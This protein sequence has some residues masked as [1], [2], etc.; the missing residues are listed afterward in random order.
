MTDLEQYQKAR[1]EAL[2][3]KLSEITK[4]VK[5]IVM[6]YDEWKQQEPEQLGDIEQQAEVHTLTDAFQ[7]GTEDQQNEVQ[8][9][10][11][12]KLEKIHYVLKSTG[13]GLVSE[14]ELLIEKCK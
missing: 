5:E 12:E 1:I 10:I 4:T 13:H 9:F 3:K 6:N 14:L 8:E 11:Q 7:Y 2:E